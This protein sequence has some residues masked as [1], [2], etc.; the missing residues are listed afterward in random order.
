MEGLKEGSLITILKGIAISIILTLLLLFIFAIVLTYTNVSEKMIPAVI[1]VVTA[2]SLLIGSSIVNRK[3][4][5]NGILNGAIIGIIYL[6]SIYLISSS[7]NGDFSITLNSVIM[8][9]AGMF[10]G[11]LGGIIGVNYKK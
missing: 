5:K 9:I 3:I 6:L 11:I 7:I 1:I 10:F 8:L 2:I 4:K